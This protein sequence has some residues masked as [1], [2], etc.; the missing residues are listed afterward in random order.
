[1]ENVDDNVDDDDVDIN[2]AWKSIRQNI[3]TQ[4]QRQCNLL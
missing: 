2:R 3:K 4:L 1:L